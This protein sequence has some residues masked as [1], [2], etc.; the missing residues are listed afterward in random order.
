MRTPH[1]QQEVEDVDAALGVV[2]FP[3][4]SCQMR[5][6]GRVTPMGIA[7]QPP[8]DPRG[9]PPRQ[10]GLAHPAL[11]IEHQDVLLD[12]PVNLV[13]QDPMSVCAGG[14]A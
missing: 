4:A 10:L 14:A 13:V 12:F 11:A 7:P 6:I 9:E 1:F 2:E 5:D 3:S 8:G